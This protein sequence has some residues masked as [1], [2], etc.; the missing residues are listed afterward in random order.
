[1]SNHLHLL[2][3][4]KN[5]DISEIMRKI[6]TSYAHW[7]NWKYERNGHVFQDRFKSENVEDDSYL[8][9]VIRYI[10]QNPV[11]TDI[12]TRPEKY[13]WSSCRDYYEEKENRIGLTSTGHILALFSN[14]RKQAI[15]MFIK[16]NEEKSNEE[17]LEDRVRKRIS[18]EKMKEEIKK[19]LKGESVTVLQDMERSERD[20]IL[21]K[22]KEI[23]GGSL[24][25]IARITGLGLHIVY[26]D[27]G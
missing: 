10:H 23:E 19:I 16:F 3:C 21:R 4:E 9:T 8:L 1:M 14:D 24:R 2:I 17:C 6:G 25:Q 11:S 7:Y 5:A 12:V 20:E 27:R 22:I 15:E 26:K 18:D 13:R